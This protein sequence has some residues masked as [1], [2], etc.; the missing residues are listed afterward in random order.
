M[1]LEPEIRQQRSVVRAINRP[2]AL[3][4]ASICGTAWNF[5]FDRS[6]DWKMIAALRDRISL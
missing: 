1:E 5:T 6:T 4:L 2:T 3:S